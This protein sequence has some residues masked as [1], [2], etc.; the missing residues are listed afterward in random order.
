MQRPSFFVIRLWLFVFIITGFI[1]SAGAN[2]ACAACDYQ[3]DEP[4][5]DCFDEPDNGFYLRSEVNGDKA[6]GMAEVMYILSTIA[7]VH[8]P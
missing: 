5:C 4:G 7:E 1:V 2:F 6:I 3:P 8:K